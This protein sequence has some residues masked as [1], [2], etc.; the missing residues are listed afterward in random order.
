MATSNVTEVSSRPG[1]VVTLEGTNLFL[2]V[3]LSVT[4]LLAILFKLISEFHRTTSEIRDLREDL[5]TH[6]NTEGHKEISREVKILQKDLINFD[7]KFDIHL[8]DYINYKDSTL[9]GL[10]GCKERT[11]HKWQRTEELFVEVK[12]DVKGL[13][14]FLHKY[15]EFKIR[16]KL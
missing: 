8:Q 1:L 9:L 4:A 14:N 2:T 7:K 3:I 16:E 6:S 5:T 13:Q 11:E 10:N 15:Q 12:G